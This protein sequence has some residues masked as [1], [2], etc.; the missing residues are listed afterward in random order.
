MHASFHH[1]ANKKKT[2]K[3]NS[4]EEKNSDVRAQ[5]ESARDAYFL[6]D[7]RLEFFFLVDDTKQNLDCMGNASCV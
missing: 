6:W 4:V 7:H 5:K 2:I 3:R 1:V